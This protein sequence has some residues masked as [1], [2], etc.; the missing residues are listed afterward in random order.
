MFAL[1]FK[2]PFNVGL[3]PAH[4]IDEVTQLALND[5]DLE[6]VRAALLVKV[7][8]AAHVAE[9][10]MLL[11][12]QAITRTRWGCVWRSPETLVLRIATLTGAESREH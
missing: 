10:L 7:Y 8:Q 1:S 3:Q 5:N 6:R 9:A 11:T 4:L 12:P 2:V